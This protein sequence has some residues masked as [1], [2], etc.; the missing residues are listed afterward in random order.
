MVAFKNSQTAMPGSRDEGKT[1]SNIL[2]CYTCQLLNPQNELPTKRIL[3][4]WWPLAASWLLMGAELPAITAVIARLPNPVINLAAYGGVVFP[5]ALIIE[6]PIIMLLAASTALCKDTA[7]YNKVRRFMMV[8]GASLTLLHILIAFTPLYYVVVKGI[9]GVPDVV[10]EPARIGL[11]IMTP[12]TWS[13]A[14]RRFNQ[15]VLIRF[16]RSQTVGIGTVIRL[17]TDGLVLL[18]GYL[19]GTI[20]GIIVATSAVAAGV[21]SEAI[22]A[23]IAARPVINSDL[24]LT[25]P[26]KPELTWPAFFTF[27]IPLA[28]TSLL[29]L[30]AN[31]IGSAAL[32]RMPDPLASLA[33][34]PVVTGLVSMFRSAGT[35]FNEVVVALLDEPYSSHSLRRF[36]TWLE[37]LSTLALLVIV[38]TPLA[39]FYFQTISALSDNLAGMARVGTWLALP[40]PAL[41][42]LQS[43]YQ[44]AILHGR[45]TGGIIEA[46]VV[47]LVASAVTLAAGVVWGQA[48]G[49]YIGLASLSIST[50]MQTIWLWVRSQPVFNEIHQRDALEIEPATSVAV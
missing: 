15:G 36:A 26:V 10:V 35:A 8:A 30:L 13:I 47:Y 5:L 40:L 34:W 21:V 33:A 43:W 25:S 41:S 32:S 14:Y 31:P 23:G 39:P 4:T 27:Y 3:Q 24:R 45:R 7:S 6:A 46:V 29:I 11:M 28:M 20:P 49:L 2:L 44:G 18:A 9:L 50:L 22:Y 42:V 19:I 1:G 48:T 37:G 16:N 17:S 12:W 38:A